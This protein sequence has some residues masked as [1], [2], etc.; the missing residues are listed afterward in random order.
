MLQLSGAW[1][2]GLSSVPQGS[3]LARLRS[4]HPHQVSLLGTP[5]WGLW[6]SG[7]CVSPPGAKSLREDGKKFH[8]LHLAPN[9]CERMEKKSILSLHL[10]PNLHERMG[11][12]FHPLTGMIPNLNFVVSY[13]LCS[14][15]K[16][17]HRFMLLA[18]P[19]V[20]V[21]VLFVVF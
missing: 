7:P 2:W 8:P 18:L 4:S 15:K 5:I 12:K 1:L 16:Y 6:H 13:Y 14:S 21:V 11:K 17:Y 9:L 19:V 3:G 10:A 20:V